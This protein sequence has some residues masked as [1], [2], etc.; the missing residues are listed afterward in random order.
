MILF[1]FFAITLCYYC[2]ISQAQTV[3]GGK[4]S[5]INNSLQTLKNQITQQCPRLQPNSNSI[6]FPYGPSL[7]QK[8][9]TCPHDCILHQTSFKCPC[10]FILI[11]NSLRCPQDYILHQNLLKCPH[12]YRTLTRTVQV[13]YSSQITD[14]LCQASSK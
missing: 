2:N 4:C 13:S 6:R 7:H 12:D 3:Q 14:V 1:L 9:I 5:E 11:Y 8:L 10:D